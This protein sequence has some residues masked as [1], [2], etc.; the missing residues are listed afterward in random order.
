MRAG[1]W[2]GLVVDS[3]DESVTHTVACGLIDRIHRA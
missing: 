3:D 2:Y 1:S